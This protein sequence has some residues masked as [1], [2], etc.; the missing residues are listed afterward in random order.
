MRKL[1]V[2]QVTRFV[3][4]WWCHL[5]AS[6]PLLSPPQ[7]LLPLSAPLSLRTMAENPISWISAFLLDLAVN[8]GNKTS[9]SQQHNMTQHYVTQHHI[10]ITTAIHSSCRECMNA[11]ERKRTRL[12]TSFSISRKPENAIPREALREGLSKWGLLVRLREA[13]DSG[14]SR[15]E[16]STTNSG[17]SLDNSPTVWLFCP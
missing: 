7:R 1:K 8:L 4:P 6:R 17:M 14:T 13:D 16:L 2:S 5:P 11:P 15:K 3:V 9:S 12:R 10:T